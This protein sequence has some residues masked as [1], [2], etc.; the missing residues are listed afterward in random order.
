[1]RRTS[2]VLA[3]LQRNSFPTSFKSLQ[4]TLKT[5]VD[6]SYIAVAKEN[7]NWHVAGRRLKASA[8]P[9][10]GGSN[11]TRVGN[12]FESFDSSVSQESGIFNA[13]T[14]F[15]RFYTVHVESVLRSLSLLH[16]RFLLRHHHDRQSGV[17]RRQAVREYKV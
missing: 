16:H 12:P 9:P 15:V 7:G 8:L 2:T 17:I 11:A 1:M 4:V 14:N 13:T 6:A 5:V 10:H 3:R